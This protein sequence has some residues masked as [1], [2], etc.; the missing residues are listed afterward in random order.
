MKG[1]TVWSRAVGYF[2]LRG[3]VGKYG[4]VLLTGALAILVGSGAY[5]SLAYNNDTGHGSADQRTVYGVVAVDANLAQDPGSWWGRT[6]QVRGEI[7][8]C[9][10]IPSLGGEPCNVLSADAELIPGTGSLDEFGQSLRSTVVPLPVV[11]A[12]LDP[13]R[14]VL[15]RAPL[16][17][18][19]IPAPQAPRWGVVATYTVR[20]MA[21]PNVFCGVNECVEGRLL[22]SAT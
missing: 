14:T 3:L 1:L 13:W 9:R 10:P 17:G 15:R 4:T 6:I 19:L 18:R 20:L 22:D 5:L 16:L 2:L 8:P 21:V 12:G 11:R 7:V